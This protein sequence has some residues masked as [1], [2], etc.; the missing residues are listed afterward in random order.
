MSKILFYQAYCLGKCYIS[1]GH[2]MC[3]LFP[4]PIESPSCPQNFGNIN[5]K[6]KKVEG[7]IVDWCL[8]DENEKIC[9]GMKG[10]SDWFE[11]LYDRLA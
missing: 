9:Y 5:E 11:G 8:E 2:K 7:K 6:M 3:N 10:I 1:E 4:L